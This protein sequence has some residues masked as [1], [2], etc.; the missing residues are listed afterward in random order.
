MGSA[1]RRSAKG[2]MAIRLV[3]RA[4]R[5]RRRTGWG[6]M[7]SSANLTGRPRLNVLSKPPEGF[8]AIRRKYGRLV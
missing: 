2:T 4:D 1:T 6:F 3:C 8:F 5:E 7:L